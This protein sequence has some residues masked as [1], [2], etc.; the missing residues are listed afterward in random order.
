MLDSTFSYDEDGSARNWDTVSDS[1]VFSERS[2]VGNLGTAV[3]IC[4]SGS[5]YEFKVKWYVC[6][7]LD[8]CYGSK[9]KYELKV[10]QY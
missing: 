9:E 1:G 2:N 3:G 5:G 7:N 6:I 8:Y 10:I 4:E